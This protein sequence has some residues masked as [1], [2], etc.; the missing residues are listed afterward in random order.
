MPCQWEQRELHPHSMGGGAASR[1]DYIAQGRNL[2]PGMTSKARLPGLFQDNY[3]SLAG[4]LSP[5]LQDE[6]GTVLILKKEEQVWRGLHMGL[7]HLT[8]LRVLLFQDHKDPP[9][10]IW[11]L[12]DNQGPSHTTKI[13]QSSNQLILE[14]QATEPSFSLQGFCRPPH[15]LLCPATVVTTPTS[16]PTLAMHWTSPERSPCMIPF[17]PATYPG[18][19]VLLFAFC[20]Y[21]YF[22]G[23]KL[24]HM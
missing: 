9:R 6:A 2:N 5:S 10:Q 17:S 23:G 13:L 8:L 18:E 16:W 12:V 14:I 24:T 7:A 21:S 22:L 4:H 20:Y 15:W 11:A 1:K 3:H 19:E